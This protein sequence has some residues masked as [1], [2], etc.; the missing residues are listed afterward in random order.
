MKPACR[1]LLSLF[2]AAVLATARG[3]A[4]EEF[5]VK[6]PPGTPTPQVSVVEKLGQTIP[7]DIPLVDETGKAVK[8]GDYFTGRRPV[9]LQLG[10]YGCPMLCSL[11]SQAMA[12]S[13]R[14]LALKPGE[15]VEV[16][17]VSIDPREKPA[18]AA[19]K[20]ASI[21]NVWNKAG[22]DQA[23]H[24]LTGTE[25]DTARLADAVGFQYQWVEA[26]RQFAHPAVLMVLSPQGKVTRYLY[27]VKYGPTTLRL[28]LVES[29]DGKVGS[30]TDRFILTCFQYDGKQGKYALMAIR[31]LQAGALVTVVTLATVIFMFFRWEKRRQQRLT[32]Q[33]P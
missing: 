20:K 24:L 16:L 2:I 15:E 5:A 8:L 18:L 4:A 19:E 3:T 12:D 25:K 13:L 6:S 27:G 31:A 33:A 22:A 21:V 11:V 28:S 10:Y 29:A 1:H 17:Y 7:L 14:Q 23:I 9:I 30:S 26:A 32:A